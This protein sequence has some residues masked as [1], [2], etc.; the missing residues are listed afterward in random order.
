M[1]AIDCRAVGVRRKRVLLLLMTSAIFGPS[2]LRFGQ[3]DRAATNDLHD[4]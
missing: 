1:F 3:N 4:H 2:R